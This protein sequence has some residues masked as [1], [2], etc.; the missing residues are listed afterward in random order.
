MGST[1]EQNFSWGFELT[2]RTILFSDQGC[3]HDAGFQTT[4]AFGSPRRKT[5]RRAK[6]T[7]RGEDSRK[8][9]EKNGERET[10]RTRRNGTGRER[11]FRSQP[12]Y[13]VHTSE[14]RTPSFLKMNI[15]NHPW[16]QTASQLRRPRLT[17]HL[18]VSS[19][20]L[21]PLAATLFG[22]V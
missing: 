15:G 16:D 10:A 14:E 12:T 7:M 17:K 21:Y 5:E 9:K 8:E 3:F 1:N 2:N 11:G 18:F 4:F 20:N 6:T 22:L 13:L 19:N